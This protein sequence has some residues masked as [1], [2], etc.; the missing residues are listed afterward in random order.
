MGGVQIVMPV[1]D[2][3]QAFRLLCGGEAV[4][5]SWDTRQYKRST[6]SSIRPELKMFTFDEYAAML[7]NSTD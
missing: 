7:L 5:F 3:V 2:A 1:D 4:E 6:A